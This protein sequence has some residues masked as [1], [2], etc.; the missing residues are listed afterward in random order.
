[1]ELILK[2]LI[3]LMELVSG[4][5][6]Q[7]EWEMKT[8]LVLQGIIFLGLFALVFF[9]FYH[10]Y[11]W[12]NPKLRK[13]LFW[14]VGI[15]LLVVAG[16]YL[17]FHFAKGYISDRLFFYAVASPKFSGILWFLLAGLSVGA[18]L[19]F[20][21]KIESWSPVKFLIALWLIFFLLAVGVAGMREG[22]YG[23]YEPFTRT[24]WE[25]AG[26]LSLVKN[27]PDFLASY[28]SLQSQ[29]SSHG[30]THPPG[31]VLILYVLQQVFQANLFWLTILVTAL[32]GLAVFPIYYFWRRFADESIVRRGLQIFIFLPSVVLFGSVSMDFVLVFFAWL[33]LAAVYSGW[34]QY[35]WLAL[36]GGLLAGWALLLN[37]L[38]LLF[39]PVF[40]FFLVYLFRGADFDE[41][42]WI[43]GRALWSMAGLAL[44]FASLY[45]LTG[46]SILE[47]FFAANNF[48]HEVVQSNFVSLWI[49]FLYL[50]MNVVSFGIYLGLPNVVLL[51]G[52]IKN[53]ISEFQ[54]AALGFY[55]I[56]FL[57]L[58]GV[59]QG[60]T[61]RIWLFLTPLF[62]L[63]ISQ[64]IAAE[65]RKSAV[66]SLL[67][68]QIIITQIL[69]YTY[70]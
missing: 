8:R 53:F 57:L 47:N 65:S 70:W 56:A 24:Q 59:F 20:R 25:Y 2:Y 17:I 43:A 68:F 32:G 35:W 67:F 6:Y 66:I 19:R 14:S 21:K 10:K 38:F 54:P 12:N 15:L 13:L 23:I 18:F 42:R 61:E 22:A 48:Q 46:Y 52:K 44:F 39:A 60:E 58:I 3:P 45:Y 41:R 49:Y 4:Q 64:V 29:L 26:D 50:I 63:P 34:K 69:F 62:I 40:L 9:Y 30:S 31:Y 51:F 33:A 11:F 28:T 1:M 7:P 37:F 36:L 27:I 55:M 16:K 5:S